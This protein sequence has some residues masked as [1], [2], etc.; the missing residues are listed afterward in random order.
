MAT[1]NTLIAYASRYGNVEKCARE[2]FNLIDGKVDICNLNNRESFPDASTY[3][4]IIIGGSIYQGKIQESVSDF[5]DINLDI[6]TKKRLGLFIS[7]LY[8]DERAAKE[9]Q[10]AFP[11]ELLNS[12]VVSDYFGGEIDKSRLSFLERIITKQMAMSGEL[13][14]SISHEKIKKFAKKMNPSDVSEK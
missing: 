9:L 6:L 10:E 3:D 14:S 2:L 7:C 1:N 13:V 5:C 8:S 11:T 4:S 12:A